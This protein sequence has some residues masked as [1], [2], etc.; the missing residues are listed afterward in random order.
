MNFYVGLFNFYLSLFSISTYSQRETSFDVLSKFS[1]FLHTPLEFPRTP[2]ARVCLRA[3]VRVCVCAY[4]CAYAWACARVYAYAC[5]CVRVCVYACAGFI[6]ATFS[7]STFHAFDRFGT[8]S[9]RLRFDVR[10]SDGFGTLWDK[11]KKFFYFFCFTYCKSEI[12]LAYLFQTVA[13]RLPKPITK[14][15]TQWKHSKQ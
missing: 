7:S 2:Y 12:L 10:N 5:T 13:D 8:L 1:E 4:V 9:D 15:P 6:F 14:P 11:R 3:C